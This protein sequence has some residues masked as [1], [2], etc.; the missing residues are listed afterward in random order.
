MLAITIRTRVEAKKIDRQRK[1]LVVHDYQTG[2]EQEIAYDKLLLA[3]GA[4]PIRPPLPGIDDHRIMT[5]R[6]LQDMDQIKLQ[7]ASAQKVAVIG[8]GFIGLEMVEMLKHLGKEVTLVELQSQVLPQ[9]DSDIAKPI[10]VELIEKGVEVILSD[11]IASFN[12]EKN[13]VTA[14]LASGKTV[15]A[16]IVILSIGVQ[17][18]TELAATAGLELGQRK[19]IK[20]NKFQQTSDPD[21]YAAGDAV[22]T[23][24]PIFDRKVVVPLGGPANRQGRVVADHIFLR[25]KAHAYPGSIGTAIVRVFDITAGITGYNEKWLKQANIPYRHTIVTY[26]HHA[27]YY[28]GALPISV[29]ILW[30]PHD[31]RLL[32]GQVVGCQGVDKRLD[33]LSTAIAGKLTVEDICHLEL[34]YAPPFGSARDII[35]LAGFAAQN[36]QDGLLKPTYSLPQNGEKQLLDV[37]PPEMAVAHPIPGSK[38]IPVEQL[39]SRLH[40]LDKTQPITTICALGKLSYFAYRILQQNGFQADTFAGGY[41][42]YSR[43]PVFCQSTCSG[44]KDHGGNVMSD[45]EFAPIQL[46]TCGLACP[47]PIMKI[48]EALDRLSPGQTMVVRASDPGF[49]KD[50]PAYCQ[51][52]GMEFLGLEKDKGILVAKARKS[53]VGAAPQASVKA[54]DGATIVVFS[55]DLDKVLA[56]LVIANGAA[57]MGGKVTMFFTFWGLNALRKDGKFK[58]PGKTFMDKMFGWMMPKGVNK[59]PLSRMHMAGMGTAMMKGRMESKDLPTAPKLLEQARQAGIRMVACSMS[60]E[61]MGIKIEELIDGVEVGGVAD[62]LAASRQTATNLFI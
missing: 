33:V 62:F 1:I 43:Q 55:C 24:E 47:G 25:E 32:G 35:N 15:A 50:F 16:D 49:A 41:D 12:P 5:L 45:S 17:C 46:D 9:L 18:E 8:A 42:L 31:G 28:P 6:T 53:H 58:V 3:P 36:I 34:A 29:K 56:S 48:K 19:A 38:N 57:A 10:E 23:S 21:I 14:T 59:L 51:A 44:E 13:Q 61:A 40:E 11:G 20:V 52:T 54:G 7:V 39:R 4:R 60:M 2:E 30:S 27:G 22:E 37:R 26:F